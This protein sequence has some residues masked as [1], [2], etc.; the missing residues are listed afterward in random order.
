[1]I[2]GIYKQMTCCVLRREKAELVVQLYYVRWY[3]RRQSLLTS[4][5]KL[6]NV[7]GIEWKHVQ[8]N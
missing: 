5:E 8:E 2:A 4:N 1:M 3:A 7:Y 6:R